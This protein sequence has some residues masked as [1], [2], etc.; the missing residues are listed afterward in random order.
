MQSAFCCMTCKRCKVDFQI[1]SRWLWWQWSQVWS[2]W[3]VVLMCMSQKLHTN[4]AVEYIY[5]SRSSDDA[6]W[7]QHVKSTHILRVM[8][9][10]KKKVASH[11]LHEVVLV[12][13]RHR[14]RSPGISIV[15]VTSVQQLWPIRITFQVHN[16][17]GSI[18][19]RLASACVAWVEGS[20]SGMGVVCL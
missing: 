10:E 16:W 6:L 2:G 1:Y 9:T 14:L 20:V 11:R 4:G 8:T 12:S 15:H 13:H 18:A 19:S 7:L 3:I 5:G 17:A